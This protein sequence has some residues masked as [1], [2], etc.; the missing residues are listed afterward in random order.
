MN[1]N[2]EYRITVIRSSGKYSQKLSINPTLIKN[3]KITP[4]VISSLSTPVLSSNILFVKLFLFKILLIVWFPLV[5]FFEI[6]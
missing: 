3:E 2:N 1:I 5:L 6:I 4:T